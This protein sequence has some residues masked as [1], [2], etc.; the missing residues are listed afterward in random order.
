MKEL[1]CQIK[2]CLAKKILITGATQGIGEGVLRECLQ[3]G[4]DIAFCGLI[5][6]G[7]QPL[8]AD[9]EAAGGKSFFRAF[10]VADHDATRQFV[11]DSIAALGGLDGVVSNAGTNFYYGING[12]SYE[13]IIH[14]LD[15]NFFPAWVIAQEA[16]EALKACGQGKFVITS[17]IHSQMSLP[18]AF[19]YDITKAALS[20]FVRSITLEW[21]KDNIQAVAI[22]PGL[23]RTPLVDDIFNQLDDPEGEWD[24]YRRWHPVKREG[25]PEDI[26]GLVVYL[27]SD[28]NRFI[29]GNTIMVDG[30]LHIQI[31]HD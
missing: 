23:I 1:Q 30:G 15:V 10:D 29:T 7:S 18:G 26:A 9:I 24:K 14:A 16:Y 19:P 22:A 8:I 11:K 13:Q 5:D 17:S 27:L 4:A 12:A 3:A 6:D 31:A 20:A 25:T 21:S 28:A 2:V